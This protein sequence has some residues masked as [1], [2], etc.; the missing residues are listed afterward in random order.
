MEAGGAANSTYCSA[1][2]TDDSL[3]ANGALRITSFHNPNKTSLFLS[4]SVFF[5]FLHPSA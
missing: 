3:S 1:N 4:L 5:S 2:L